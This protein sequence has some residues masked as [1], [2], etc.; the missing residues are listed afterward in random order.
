MNLLDLME[1][2]I[3]PARPVWRGGRIVPGSDCGFVPLLDGDLRW[4]GH[5]RARSW[6]RWYRWSAR[7]KAW[8]CLD[9]ADAKGI[10]GR[11]DTPPDFA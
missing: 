3:A 10:N 6:G 11:P 1:P 7:E 8:C 9:S 5:D 2:R 4:L